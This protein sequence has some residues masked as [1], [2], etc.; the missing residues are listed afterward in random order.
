[1]NKNLEKLFKKKEEAYDFKA[2]LDRA[3]VL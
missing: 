1:M 3:D 2:P